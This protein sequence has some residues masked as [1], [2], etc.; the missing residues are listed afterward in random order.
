[1]KSAVPL[2]HAASS[3]KG[4]FP[5]DDWFKLLPIVGALLCGI[6]FTIVFHRY[7]LLSGFDLVQADPGDSRLIAS[8]LEHWFKVF[9][10]IDHWPSPPWFF[11]KQGT[12]G[13]SDVLLGM[14]IPYSAFRALGAGTFV[15]MNLTL[16]LLSFLSYLACLWLLRGV[17]AF[18]WLASVA[19][20]AFFAF[21]YPKLAA[22]PHVKLCFDMLQPIILG[23]LLSLLIS[24]EVP[25][26]LRTFVT[27]LAA[28]LAFALLASTTFICAWFLALLMLLFLAI[29]LLVSDLRLRLFARLH[30][31]WLV[32]CAGLFLGS[33]ALL[34]LLSLFLSAIAETGPWPWPEVLSTIPRPRQLIWMGTDNLVWGWLAGRR[35]DLDEVNWA[36]MRIGYGAGATLAWMALVAFSLMQLV[37]GM[38]PSSAEKDGPRDCVGAVVGVLLIASLAF[39]LLGIQVR[40]HSPWY[41]AYKLLPGG[42]GVRSVS[43]YVL[44]L[45]LPVAIGFAYALD[46]F[47]T[48]PHSRAALV[49]VTA[50]VLVVA[51][52]Q[53]AMIKRTYSAHIAEQFETTIADMVDRHCAAFY[54]KP[55]SKHPLQMQDIDPMTEQTFNAK[56]YLAANPDVAQNWPGSAFEHFIKHGKEENRSLSP[57]ETPLS[58]HYHLTASL[59]ALAA[60]V[61]TL[62]GLSGKIPPGWELLQVFGQ[63]VDERVKRWMQ[64]NRD[65]RSVCLL[66]HD[67]DGSEIPV[68]TPSTFFSQ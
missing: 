14:A 34:P 8:V 19:G 62:N 38:P 57:A 12:L 24:R 7:T 21:N 4:H 48:R 1:M 25:S 6:G 44:T 59:A 68:R 63:N 52:E 43:R 47:L 51:T 65:S 46:R 26:N 22:L 18:A 64:R 40:G 36:E 53:L 27:C 54:L 10:G 23:L 58:G 20:A 35:P 5:Q 9:Q 55:T 45:S 32:A 3:W 30:Q 60:G 66:E 56:A 29:A 28:A 17:L 42:L 61:P 49:L 31:R 39:V 37:R 16:V 11:P 33:L 41:A 2:P 15:A 13:Y 67:L 50:M